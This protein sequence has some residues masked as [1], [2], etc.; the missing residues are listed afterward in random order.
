MLLNLLRSN[1]TNVA[2]LMGGLN[3]LGVT[4]K[5]EDVP[6]APEYPQGRPALAEQSTSDTGKFHLKVTRQVHPA[7]PD[8]LDDID[9][10]TEVMT[11][12]FGLPRQYRLIIILGV[13][14]LILGTIFGALSLLPVGCDYGLDFACPSTTETPTA[15]TT[16]TPSMTPTVTATPTITLTSTH[17]ATPTATSTPSLTA[18]NTSIPTE[19]AIAVDVVLPPTPCEVDILERSITEEDANEML[20]LAFNDWLACGDFPELIVNTDLTNIAGRQRSYLSTLSR[21]QLD[22]INPYVDAQNRDVEEQARIVGY[23]GLV[24]MIVAIQENIITFNDINEI[25]QARGIELER[26]TELGFDIDFDP[27]VNLHYLVIT[28]GFPSSP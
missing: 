7:S 19:T 15:T 13:G 6:N 9:P 11:A 17:T 4:I 25:F 21:D 23:D 26:Y 10:D 18:T 14:A 2:R 3:N 24:E 20:L 16:A 1:S 8:E 5:P 28:I 22:A 12:E 27:A